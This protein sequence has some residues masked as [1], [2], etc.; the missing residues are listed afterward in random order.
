MKNQLPKLLITCC[1]FISVFTL[2]AQEIPV[3]QIK[4][5]I[6]S[7]K[8]DQRGPYYRIKWFCKDGSIRDPKDPCPENIGPG[9]Q[10]ATYKKEVETLAQK[11]QIY[12]GN[13]LS[14]NDY[15][16]FWD[17]G[18][19]HARV[20]QYQIVK[21]LTSVDDGWIY[22][23]GRY[24][25]GSMQSEDEET[26]GR[27]YFVR[28]LSDQSIVM[29]DYY[30]LKESLKDIPHSGDSNQAQLMRSQSKVLAEALPDFMDIRIKIHGNPDKSDIDV[31]KRYQSSNKSKLTEDQNKMFDDLLTTLESYYTPVSI[32][33]LIEQTNMIKSNKGLAGEI[34]TM[35]NG[36]QGENT[37]PGKV[38]R[39]ANISVF[40]RK[41]MD[42]LS[43]NKDRM[44]LLDLSNKID[45]SLF[46]QS[47]EWKP[48]DLRGLMSKIEV[49]SYAALG[50]GLIEFW[51]WD[52]I[53]QDPVD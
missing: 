29:T 40:M 44:I 36:Y 11:H 18:N 41:G 4:N 48:E 21:Y 37:I 39:L 27:D 34:V 51:E 23:K 10:H 46:I 15:D 12:F 53:K 24:Y 43:L 8:N 16:E 6:K 22:R 7:Y 50:S 42:N 13:I 35:L 38:T 30:L 20:K 9:I 52:E 25:R 32:A 33:S 3:D 19:N 17:A 14:Y 49:L 45:M 2:A 47:Q 5:E 31:V 28:I 26:W 1:L